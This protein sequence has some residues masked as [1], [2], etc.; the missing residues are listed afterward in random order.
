MHAQGTNTTAA[1]CGTDYTKW[2]LFCPEDEE[3]DLF[4]NMTPS[5]P[6]FKAMEKDMDERHRKCVCWGMGR[7]YDY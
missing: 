2:D 7:E 5:N 4:N 1:G 3:D 6:A